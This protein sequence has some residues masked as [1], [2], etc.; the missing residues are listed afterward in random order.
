MASREL[1][2]CHYGIESALLHGHARAREILEQQYKASFSVRVQVRR[3]S[4][5]KLSNSCNAD[6]HEYRRIWVEV[7]CKNVMQFGNAGNS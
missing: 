4:G 3:F 2:A 6:V 5:R 7:L 1:V